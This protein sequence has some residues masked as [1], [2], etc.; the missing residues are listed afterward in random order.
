MRRLAFERCELGHVGEPHV[1]LNDV[2]LHVDAV[3]ESD[4]GGPEAVE[5]LVHEHRRLALR[6]AGSTVAP[7][8]SLDCASM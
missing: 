8:G 1:G 5:Y 4:V 7:H 2:Q 6:E 3:E